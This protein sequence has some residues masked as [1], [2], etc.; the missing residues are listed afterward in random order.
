[1]A[2]VQLEHGHVRIANALEEAI[3]FAKFSATQMKI[4]RCVIRLTW[5]WRARTVRISY[6]DLALRCNTTAAG[7]FRKE[8][9]ELT[10]EGVITVIEHAARPHA[11]RLRDQQGL[12]TM[13]PV[14][15][16]SER[17]R[18]ALQ[19]PPGACRRPA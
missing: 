19:R 3:I 6:Q 17:A 13:G 15:R 5:G 9:E 10:R 8:F 14:E 18:G 2:D 1:V 7:G 4:V 16:A 12:R 11:R